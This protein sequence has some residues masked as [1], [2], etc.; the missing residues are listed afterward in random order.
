MDILIL[1]CGSSVGSPI[2]GK[3]L[4]SF[5]SKDFRTR[6]SVLVNVDNKKILIDSGAD[7]RYQA[8]KNNIEDISF[9][10]Y[11][12]SHAD[13][14]HGIDDLRIFSYMKQERIN[15]FGNPYTVRDIKKNLNFFEPFI[16]KKS[17]AS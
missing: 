11:T 14:T 13:H 5:D 15:C 10:L 7:F 9:V 12:H 2:I 8:L 16:S 1:G 6:S 3:R 4:T 17:S